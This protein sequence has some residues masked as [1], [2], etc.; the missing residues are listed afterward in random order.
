MKI[1]IQTCKQE[2]IKKEKKKRR[3]EWVLRKLCTFTYVFMRK[4]ERGR[5]HLFMFCF[6]WQLAC[7]SEKNKIKI[8]MVV[9]K[10]K[11]MDEKL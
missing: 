3:K 1:H 11:D 7:H 10:F 4:K 2:N 5:E 8:I 9:P 6:V